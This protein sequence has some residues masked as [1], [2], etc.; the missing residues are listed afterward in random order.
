MPPIRV[1]VHGAAG[2]MGR[3]VIS[4][5]CSDGELEA[6]GA[7]DVKCQQDHM[8]L[9]DGSGDIPYSRD[10]EEVLS[11]C[12]PDCL[13]DFT[14]GDATM[15]AARLAAERGVDL[16]IGTTGLSPRDIEE[17]SALCQR[18]HVGAVVAPNFSLG[19]VLM[20]HMS[21]VAARFFD[22]AE[23]IEMHHEEKADAPSGT[24]I[25][26]ARAMVEAR[27]RPF[28]RRPTERETIAAT[29][30]GE[31]DG[32]SV[33]SVR[34]PGLLAHQEVIVGAPGQ[35]LSIRHDAISRESFM[36]GV[37]L[38]IKKVAEH[39]ELFYGLEKLLGL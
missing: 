6:V 22:H 9:P 39:K 33:H 35:T 27:G 10:L 38:A 3:E 25:A 26:T 14:A 7:V 23:I 5:L 36:P 4:A 13:V 8:A 28:T 21:R 17:V 34:L 16:V 20:V 1:V 24:A 37:V 2:R 19:A 31:I 12:Q 32:V 15:A 30:G 18:H 11:R 29:R